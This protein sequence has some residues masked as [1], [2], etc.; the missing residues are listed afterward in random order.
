M[1]KEKPVLENTTGLDDD[2][3]HIVWPE[4]E[5]DGEVRI[6]RLY[7]HSKLVGEVGKRLGYE[8]EI[9]DLVAFIPTLDDP[10][11]TFILTLPVEEFKSYI[12]QK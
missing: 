3:Y 9:Q 2:V 8:D 6:V 7:R 10:D 11:D 12:K 1:K 4:A 5:F